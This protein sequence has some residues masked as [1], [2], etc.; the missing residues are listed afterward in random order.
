[1][2][3]VSW[4][5]EWQDLSAGLLGA[6]A[7]IWT[8]RWTLLAERRRQEQETEALRTALGAELRHFANRALDGYREIVKMM[9][10][11]SNVGDAMTV[12]PQQIDKVAHFPDAVIYPQT[13]ASLG[14]LGDYAHG[15]VFFF[16]QVTL[17]QDALRRLPTEVPVLPRVQLVNIALALF[18][19]ADAA[20]EALPAFAAPRWSD[21]DRVFESQVTE[22]RTS[23]TWVKSLLG[24]S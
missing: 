12:T 14:A 2:C 1:V 22:A 24:V 11:A 17:V 15:I 23:V 4:I 3:W 13:A 20:R 7:L 10:A 19:A 18:N 21:G 5:K 6:A 8:V 9:A 16:G